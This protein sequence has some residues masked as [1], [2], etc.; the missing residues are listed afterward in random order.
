MLAYIDPSSGLPL[1]GGIG[2]ALAALIAGAGSLAYRFRALVAGALRRRGVRVGLALALLCGAAAAGA[3][4]RS[5]GGALGEGGAGAIVIGMDGLDPG[6][7]EGL[8]A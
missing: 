3:H 1:L 4:V 2:A 8:M 6:T 7:L 5:G